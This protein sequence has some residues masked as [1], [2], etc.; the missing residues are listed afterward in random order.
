MKMSNTSLHGRLSILVTMGVIVACIFSF[1]SLL[2]SAQAA[3][4]SA[5]SERAR[6]VSLEE[7]FDESVNE[8][9]RLSQSYSQ[10]RLTGVTLDALRTRIEEHFQ[11]AG[12]QVSISAP[13]TD[14]AFS[15]IAVTASAETAQLLSSFAELETNAPIRKLEIRKTDEHGSRLELTFE[16]RVI[17]EE[18]SVADG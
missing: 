8:R 17:V 3:L 14:G 12:G 5:N 7:R 10:W 6:I 15:T 2:Q 4:A 1:V 16:I 18:E 11:A 9:R 13:A